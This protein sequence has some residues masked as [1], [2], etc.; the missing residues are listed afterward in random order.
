V[1]P[2]QWC[3]L[4]SLPNLMI[5]QFHCDI[6]HLLEPSQHSQFCHLAK[7]HWADCCGAKKAFLQWTH[8]ETNVAQL[9]LRLREG[10]VVA[11]YGSV[12]AIL[13]DR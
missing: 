13:T 3:P 7:C 11:R 10:N 12:K 4:K 9:R 1:I 5:V 8:L 6:R 2:I